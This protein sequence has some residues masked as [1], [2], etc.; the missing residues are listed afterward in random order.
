MARPPGVLPLR[1][2]RIVYALCGADAILFWND[3]DTF[4][5]FAWMD[6]F[7]F[8]QLCRNPALVLRPEP[9]SR[10]ARWFGWARGREWSRIC[11]SRSATAQLQPQV[12]G[13]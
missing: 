11:P 4:L 1:D 6:S 10:L 13:C 8:R 7:D 5:N 3:R 2:V 12:A 9:A